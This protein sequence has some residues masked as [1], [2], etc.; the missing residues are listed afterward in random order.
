MNT[1]QVDHVSPIGDSGKK[2]THDAID[3]T[4]AGG[5]QKK[6]DPVRVNRGFQSTSQTNDIQSKGSSFKVGI[7][8]G[9]SIK[10]VYHIA[11]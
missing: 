1:K 3:T 7:L 4:M 2:I 11:N 9:F 10:M 8:P 6:R 5:R